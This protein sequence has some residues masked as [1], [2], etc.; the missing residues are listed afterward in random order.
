MER[1]LKTTISTLISLWDYNGNWVPPGNYFFC[2]KKHKKDSV[3]GDISCR[4]FK[5]EFEFKYKTFIKMMAVSQSRL[6]K[7]AGMKHPDMPNYRAPT[8]TPDLVVPPHLRNI[9]SN[10]PYIELYDL[11]R[12][13]DKEDEKCSICW[14]EIKNT[15][16]KTLDCDHYFH[17]RCINRWEQTQNTC[18]LC[19]AVIEQVN[20]EPERQRYSLENIILSRI[21]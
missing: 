3:V 9:K 7:H 10:Y 16:K 21:R 2:V 4:G 13:N 8:S 6:A 14:D 5:A 12:K 17:I 18:P 15:E 20:P 11:P 1:K 19:R